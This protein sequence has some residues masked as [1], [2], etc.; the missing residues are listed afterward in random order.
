MP[1]FL[2]SLQFNHLGSPAILDPIVCLAEQ[3]NQLGPVI[4]RGIQGL[5]IPE[6]CGR[7]R[8][9]LL[10]LFGAGKSN[11]EFVGSGRY[12]QCVG[13]FH[14]PASEFVDPPPIN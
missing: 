2:H 14:G 1:F 11:G 3:V 5:V 12:S 13:V 9:R 7:C 8:S 6:Y 4:Y 10:S